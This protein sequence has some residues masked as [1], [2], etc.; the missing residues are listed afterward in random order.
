MNSMLMLNH[1]LTS[2]YSLSNLELHARPPFHIVNENAPLAP[3][4]RP[5][6]LCFSFERRRGNLTQIGH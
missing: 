6:D 5:D 3:T 2:K 1:A 4:A